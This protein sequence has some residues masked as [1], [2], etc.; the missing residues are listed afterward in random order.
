[1]IAIRNDAKVRRAVRIQLLGSGSD[2]TCKTRIAVMERGHRV[3]SMRQASRPCFYR[4]QTL[5]IGS[6]R[7]SKGHTDAF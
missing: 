3:Q 4:C 6:G 7:M 2:E 1:M 5:C